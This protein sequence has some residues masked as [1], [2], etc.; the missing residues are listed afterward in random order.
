MENSRSKAGKQKWGTRRS[1]WGKGLAWSIIKYR[2]PVP[3][4]QNKWCV[5]TANQSD[6]FLLSSVRVFKTNSEQKY[7]FCLQGFAFQI[8][9]SKDGIFQTAQASGCWGILWECNWVASGLSETSPLAPIL[10]LCPRI[11]RK[12]TAQGMC[13]YPKSQLQDQTS[14]FILRC[15]TG[16]LHSK[17]KP[18]AKW[19]L[20]QPQR[21]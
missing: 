18:A 14:A 7:L 16:K 3:G 9:V 20:V 19:G 4:T 21:R 5:F 13:L 8:A 10:P 15:F 11:P 17:I 2:E 12:I 1:T 6:S